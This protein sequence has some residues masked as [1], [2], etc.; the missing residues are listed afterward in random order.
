MGTR[1]GGNTSGSYIC[2]LPKLYEIAFI[3]VC[4]ASSLEAAHGAAGL[5]S[6]TQLQ[7]QIRFWP[8]HQWF[9]TCKYKKKSVRREQ[10][11]LRTQE[12]STE[13]HNSHSCA[14][15]PVQILQVKWFCFSSCFTPLGCTWTMGFKAVLVVLL[16]VHC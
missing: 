7:Q 1:W 13:N 12:K 10:S 5:Q 4:T 9:V 14:E 6:F 2:L 3:N 11:W 16:V 15:K 8:M